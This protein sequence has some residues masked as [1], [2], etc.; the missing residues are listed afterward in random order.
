MKTTKDFIASKSW[1][2]IFDPDKSA[3]FETNNFSLLIYWCLVPCNTLLVVLTHWGL[4]THVCISKLTIIGS[5]NGLVPGWCQA[6]NWTTVGILLIRPLGTN[7]NEILIEIHEFS[8]KKIHFKMSPGNMIADILSQPQ[9]VNTL[10][11]VQNGQ[12]FADCTLKNAISWT[13]VLYIDSNL[14]LKVH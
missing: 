9:C 14:F 2:F 4:V 6:I 12:H 8:F 10:R 3:N 7:F 5:D 13:K 1:N 11:L